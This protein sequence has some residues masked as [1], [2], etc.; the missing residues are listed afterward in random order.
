MVRPEQVLQSETPTDCRAR[1]ERTLFLGTDWRVYL[2]L[3]DGTAL[4]ARTPTW[5]A[6][7]G[8]VF[9]RVD[10][11]CPQPEPDPDFDKG[12]FPLPVVE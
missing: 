4:V 10:A 9:L 8:D 7:D 5:I 6:P 1:V 3:H 2:R 12:I 11:T